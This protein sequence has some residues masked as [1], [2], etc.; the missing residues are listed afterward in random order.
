M[1]HQL[2][3]SILV[4]ELVCSTHGKDFMSIKLMEK[5]PGTSERLQQQQLPRV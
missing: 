4:D 5:V 1:M 3:S 2:K